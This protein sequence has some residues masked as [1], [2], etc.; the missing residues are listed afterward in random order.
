MWS[1]YPGRAISLFSGQKLQNIKSRTRERGL[2]PAQI[3]HHI[4]LILRVK[5]ILLTRKLLGD[6]KGSDAK[7]VMFITKES[8]ASSLESTL[9]E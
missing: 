2:G 1:P 5:E 6:Q 4:F 8:Q 3:R 9:T 7:L